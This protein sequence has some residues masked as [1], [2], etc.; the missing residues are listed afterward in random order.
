MP[1]DQA[2]IAARE[3]Q[4]GGSTPDVASFER[5]ARAFVDAFNR[6]DRDAWLAT[7]HPDGEFRP[8][9][10]AGGRTRYR[11]HEELGSYIETLE[12]DAA[13]HRARVRTVRRHQKARHQS[14]LLRRNA[15]AVVK[16]PEKRPHEAAA[17]AGCATSG[18]CVR[19]GM[20][21]M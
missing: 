5:V 7:F 2:K 16:R 15:P 10:L 11:G 21:R 17:S 14:L 4:R 6:R 20:A 9:V 13:A 1:A 19:T 8:S 12:S 3:S 18:A